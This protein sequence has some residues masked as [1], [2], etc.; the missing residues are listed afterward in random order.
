MCRL[1]PLIFQ[2]VIGKVYW[3]SFTIII[4]WV[5][6]WI[7][8]CPW[9]PPDSCGLQR[10]F[11]LGGGFKYVLFLFGED[12]QFDLRSPRGFRCRPILCPNI[13]MKWWTPWCR[14]W[15]R[16]ESSRVEPNTTDEYRWMC[17]CFF[18]VFFINGIA[19]VVCFVLFC[20]VFFN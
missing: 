3:Q 2:G 5:G 17:F 11:Y 7:G 15:G 20:F 14:P 1:Q 12:F 9:P 16:V 6:F 18:V 13:S 8:L 10:C 19:C 4:S